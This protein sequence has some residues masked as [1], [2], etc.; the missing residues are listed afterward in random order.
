MTL[1][2]VRKVVIVGGGTAGWVSAA[3]LARVLGPLVRIELVESEEIGTVGVGEATIP[4]IRLLLGVLGIQEDDFLRHTNGTIKLGI[5]FNGWSQPGHSYM[6]AFG[7]VGRSLGLI[8]FHPYWLRARENGDRSGLWD[9]S[10]NYQAAAAG[11]F[12]R[13]QADPRQGLDAL[14]Y[15][16]HF[17]ATL[18]ARYLRVY[19]ERLGVTRTEGRIVGTRLR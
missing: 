7:A 1:Q 2:K 18:V 16:F 8:P 4:Q 15:A 9:Y 14:V 5:Q 6:H 12:D 3:T 17:D 19:A 10:F 13:V 11:R